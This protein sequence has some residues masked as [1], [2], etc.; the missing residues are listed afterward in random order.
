MSSTPQGSPNPEDRADFENADKGF[1]GSL[2]P[3]SISTDDLIH[4]PTTADHKARL[5]VTLTKRQLLQFFSTGSAEGI[6]LSGDPAVLGRLM[7][8]TD[9]ADPDFPIVTP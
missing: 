8:V 6:D 1:L 2:E 7:A 9:T 4:Y 3:M 5:T